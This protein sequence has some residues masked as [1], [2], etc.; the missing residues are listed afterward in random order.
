M[1]CSSNCLL[2]EASLRS[3]LIVGSGFIGSALA[4]NFSRSGYHTRVLSRSFTAGGAAE[5]LSSVHR[6]VGDASDHRVMWDALEGIDE[7][8]WCAGGRLPAESEDDPL[9]AIN[10]RCQPLLSLFKMIDQMEQP[11]HLFLFSSGGTIYGEV[12]GEL[13]TEDSATNPTTAYGIANLCSELLARKF[14]GAPI[15][16]L[17]IF[18]CANLYGRFQQ[19]GRSQGLIATAIA[20]GRSGDSITIFGDGESTR[21]YVHVDDMVEIVERIAASEQM[22]L[23]LN[24][25]T[26][27]G[28]TVNQVLSLVENVMGVELARDYVEVRPS[29][30]RSG[31][32]DVTLARSLAGVQPLTLSEGIERSVSALNPGSEDQR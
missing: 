13:F 3:R 16:R 22:P 10:D 9:G 5:I 31:V 11:P 7:V 8:F 26:G 19:S 21:D 17:T 32:L 1:D 2:A 25:G 27:I 6:I 23:V 14:A 15:S 4:E 28:S 18:R 24:V 30:L 20:A 12:S 29:D